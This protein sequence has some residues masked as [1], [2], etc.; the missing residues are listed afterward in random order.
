MFCYCYCY[1]FYQ[2]ERRPNVYF[3]FGI[4][5]AIYANSRNHNNAKSA[6]VLHS[7]IHQLGHSLGGI[8]KYQEIKY[9]VSNFWLSTN[10]EIGR[11][12]VSKAY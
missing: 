6:R 11:S 9:G 7:A 2:L 12:D 1:H 3:F 4:R 5:N 8:I 10:F